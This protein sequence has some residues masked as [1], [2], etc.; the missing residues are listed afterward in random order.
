MRWQIQK[1][2]RQS[3]ALELSSKYPGI[4]RDFELLHFVQELDLLQ[5]DTK[6]PRECEA[7]ES[8]PVTDP[9]QPTCSCCRVKLWSCLCELC[10]RLE[11]VISASPPE[12]YHIG[13]RHPE[14]FRPL[15][16]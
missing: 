6:N 1:R 13:V 2:P 12:L 5:P 16:R 3:A 11:Q 8:L 7:I 14:L 15:S 4:L 10:G 9:V